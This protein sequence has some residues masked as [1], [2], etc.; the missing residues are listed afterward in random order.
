MKRHQVQADGEG[1]ADDGEGGQHVARPL[2]YDTLVGGEE[3]RAGTVGL[4]GGLHQ[5]QGLPGGLD[6][7]NEPGPPLDGA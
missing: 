6:A 1:L 3:D 2:Q 5:F 4:L 7:D